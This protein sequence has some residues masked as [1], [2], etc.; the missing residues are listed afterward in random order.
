MFSSI[1]KKGEGDVGADEHQQ[2]K[3]INQQ[4]KASEQQMK[5]SNQQLRATS[6]SLKESEAKFREIFDHASDGLLVADQESRKFFMANKKIQEMLGYTED[7]LKKIGVADIHPKEDL[8]FVFQQFERQARKEI[9]V[10]RL[11]VKRK[12]G[13]VF[14]ADISTAPLMIGGKM[15]L[16]GIFRDITKEKEAEE[17]LNAKM[18]ETERL[19]KLMIGRELKMVEL[20]KE[21]KEL[22]KKYEK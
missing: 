4:L 8:P 6:E 22:K 3:A 19:N 1:S 21:I 18:E 17:K 10:A 2:V 7:E 12:D 5:A 11:P 15:Y 14:Y 16:M 20:K 9:A 13:S